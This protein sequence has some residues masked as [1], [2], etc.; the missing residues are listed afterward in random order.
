[1]NA[2]TCKD[3]FLLHLREE[4]RSKATL[5]KYNHD[6]GVFLQQVTDADTL[7]KTDFTEHLNKEKI[8]DFK[9][10]LHQ[11]YATSSANSM[12]VAMNRFLMYI[13]R[14]DLCVKLFRKQRRTFRYDDKDLSHEE[15]MRL[16]KA[17]RHKDRRLFL[18]MQAI[19]ST[20]IRVSEHK[21]ITV[22]SLKRGAAEIENKGKCRIVLLD[23]KLCRVL[24]KYC[25][26]KGIKS[27]PVFV[28]SHGKPMDRSYIWKKMKALS[29][30]AEVSPEKIFP[31]NLRHLFAVTFYR[32][33]GDIVH[34]ADL[35]GHASI[36][37]TRIYTCL[38][39]GEYK[40]HFSKMKLLLC[41]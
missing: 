34:L 29:E 7:E 9:E 4:E 5:R 16:L 2:I 24:K 19:C 35:L 20:G 31:H 1:M 17:A 8:L 10:I 15:Y 18:L 32:E 22:E 21:Y 26:S 14:G 27:G 37:T 41:G 13:G 36:D 11:K 3:K 40:N 39:A 30:E 33:T 28:S 6:V 12:L 25:R 38:T 23:R